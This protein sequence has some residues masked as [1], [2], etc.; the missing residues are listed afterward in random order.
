MPASSEYSENLLTVA[1]LSTT[2]MFVRGYIRFTSFHFVSLRNLQ[3]SL[4]KN[5]T[6]YLL[7]SISTVL[8]VNIVD[9]N[10]VKF[11]N[12]VNYISNFRSQVAK[13]ITQ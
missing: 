4:D 7:L 3:H 1:L 10:S 5:V 6:K 13:F 8:I 12:S 9:F 2:F 11:V